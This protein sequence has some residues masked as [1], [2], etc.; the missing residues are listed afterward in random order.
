MWTDGS[1]F[2]DWTLPFLLGLLFFVVAFAAVPVAPDGNDY[3]EVSSPSK[4]EETA[5]RTVEKA[6]AKGTAF[7]P[8][9]A[10]SHAG[11]VHAETSSSRAAAPSPWR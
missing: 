6:A 11:D 1:F 7:S 5:A 8:T 10:H 4:C 9:G 2:L 3:E